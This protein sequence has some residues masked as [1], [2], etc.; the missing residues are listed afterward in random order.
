[1]S[2]FIHDNYDEFML[3][4]FMKGAITIYDYKD[5]DFF[6]H[7]EEFSFGVVVIMFSYLFFIF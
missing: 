1:M 6:Y 2:T 7:Y 4:Y 3:L 5:I